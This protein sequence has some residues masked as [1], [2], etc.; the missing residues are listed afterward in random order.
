MELN[1]LMEIIENQSQRFGIEDR[2][3]VL[4]V[5]MGVDS[6]VLLEAFHRLQYSIHVVHFNHQKRMESVIEAQ[7]IKQYCTQRNIVLSII[8]VPKQSGNFQ[9][10][11]RVFRYQQLKQIASLY[12]DGIITTAHHFDDRVETYIQRLFGGSS[13]MSRG[14]MEIFQQNGDTQYFRPFLQVEKSDLYRC[15]AHTEIT[16]FED[17]SNHENHY[18]RNRI[19]NQV[20]PVIKECFP[21][22]KHAIAN[23]LE[24]IILLNE[25][26]EVEYSQFEL[27]SI[28]RTSSMIYIDCADFLSKHPYFQNSIIERSVKSLGFHLKR[29][30]YP[31]IRQVIE[32][33]QQS[34]LIKKG[35]YLHVLDGQIMI[36]L[37]LAEKYEAAP[38]DFFLCEGFLKLPKQYN[39][40]YNDRNNGGDDFFVIDQE[41]LPFLKVRNS[42][43]GD[44]IQIGSVHKRVNRLFID[45]KLPR[46][47]RHSY[48]VVEDIRTGQIVWVPMFYKIYTREKTRK[49]IYV[50]FSDGGFH[51]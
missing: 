9:N 33:G 8:D 23:D 11:A 34:Y 45:K 4:A 47:K 15:A 41:D 42:K 21:A 17:Q 27:H 35:L 16:F 29:E 36:G 39:M 46:F 20:V 7:Y 37:S 28:E 6:A 38:Y 31:E 44:E 25:Y 26:L 22:Y 13:V 32:R 43:S 24:E 5:S 10:Q 3:Y 14:G 40:W 19:R 12:Q 51:A 18:Q 30:R 2:T 49:K 1:Q 48:P 50:Y